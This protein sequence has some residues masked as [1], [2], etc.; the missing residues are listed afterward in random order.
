MGDRF[1]RQ[2]A[3]Q[4]GGVTGLLL[5]VGVA[6]YYSV[7]TATTNGQQG[8][9]A[10]ETLRAIDQVLAMVSTVQAEQ[11][12]Y[13]LTGR[14]AL[15]EPF[16]DAVR[17]LE[18][19]LSE[20]EDLVRDEPA[21]LARLA[22]LRISTTELM[23]EL[24][25]TLD[26]RHN[27]NLGGPATVEALDRE[28]RLTAEIRSQVERWQSRQKAVLAQLSATRGEA[29]SS[30]IIV[31]ATGVALTL[32]LLGFA[33]RLIVEE[34]NA[35]RRAENAQARLAAIIAST[36]DAVIGKT[37]HGVVTSWNAAAE[38]LY[39]F[40]AQ[41]A[42][43]RHIDTLFKADSN[44]N[45]AQLNER[46]ARGEH[47]NQV[48]TVRHRKDG[49]SVDVELRVSPIRDEAGAMV[50]L[51]T[52]ARDVTAR[53]RAES[54]LREKTDALEAARAR[55]AAAA[56]FAAALNQP[57]MLE[58]YRETLG[59]LARVAHA[60]LAVLYDVAD[61]E[62]PR[63]RCAI[64]P[65]QLPLES[66]IFQGEGLPATVARTGKAQE[67]SGPL[68]DPALRIR[69][70]LGEV[71]LHSVLGWPV[72]F[73]GR[74]LGVLVTGHSAAVDSERRAFV[75]AALEQLAVR[76]DGYQVEQQRLRLLADLQ[77]QSRALE[78]AR[79]E[80]E[81]ASRTK[82][83]FL[84][85]MS[86]ELRTPM[87]SI[88]GFTARLLR[89]L[90]PTVGERERD[91]LQTVDRNAKHLLGLI[92]DILDLSKIEAGKMDARPEPFDL[93]ALVREAAGQSAALLDGKPVE[94]HLD[95]PAEP[96]AIV[97]DPKLVKQVLLNLL[98]NAV[99]F[100]DRGTVTVSAATI[101]DAALGDAV[102]LAV[103][104]T[105]IGIKMEDRKKLFQRFNQLDASPSRK[106]GGTGLGLALAE[107]MIRLQGGRI[108]VT[109]EPGVG[110]EFTV[111]L[112]RVVEATPADP[113]AQR[114]ASR[115]PLP[116]SPSWTRDPGDGG[117]FPQVTILCV[118]DEPDALK[119]LQLT[120]E[121]A[122]YRV[123]TA[124][125][126][127]EAIEGARADRPDLICLDLSMPGK[128]GFAVV[129]S[130]RADPALADV[131]I[132]VVSATSEE[133]RALRAGARRYLAKP[134]EASALVEAVHELLGA[135]PGDV[136]VVEDDPDA[137]RLAADALIERGLHVRTAS[138]GREALQRLAE[139]VPGAVVLDLMM[140]VMDG[141]TVLFHLSQNPAWRMIPVVVM[142]ARTLEPSEAGML[143]RTCAAVLTKGKGDTG[144]LVEAVLQAVR[145]RPRVS[146]METTIA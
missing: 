5:L 107:R 137:R 19:N 81:R 111:V 13:L 15:R 146:L 140:P 128:D 125:G 71:P 101:H 136:L 37:V 31:S 55:L 8:G 104:D 21:N 75:A 88:M 30:A 2:I 68:H 39:G 122:G 69:F 62:P 100:T 67:L 145:P 94:L 4:F 133:S 58:T 99:K 121:D 46:V 109:S 116:S 36:D 85:A 70:G 78:S 41:E 12:G 95:L 22:A 50:G 38:R 141:F 25:G 142:T 130:L 123:L 6:A 32:A 48:E 47:V 124:R 127:D 3:T 103:R 56:E 93:G 61:H 14:E 18:G 54:L 20:L 80:A 115:L 52:I 120:F 134:A 76:M 40:S 135:E 60:P 26:R 112:P 84:A 102:R 132:L 92:N 139:A 87:N 28:E 110:S 42:I 138:N 131:P 91:A 65:D 34:L 105:G 57:G 83:E 90:G 82:S 113:P 117:I 118:D 89:T 96:V 63:S 44:G 7:T 11:R 74:T 59:C 66:P 126:H 98:S 43:G 24:K 119:Y 64:G 108:D 79:L 35:R 16:E 1:Q 72:S 86:H 97:A 17:E 51:S 9:H 77:A 23:T 114:P 143:S 106:A 33:F 10:H 29:A 53:K 129:K 49:S 73:R 144:R 45:S 27:G